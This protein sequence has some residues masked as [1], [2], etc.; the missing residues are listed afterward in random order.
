MAFACAFTMFAG[1]AFTDQADIKATEAVNMLTALGVIDGYDDGSFRPDGTVTRA[2]MAKMIFVVWNGGKSDAK[3]YQTMDSAFADTKDH[4]ARGYINFCASNNIIAGKSATTFAPDATVTGQEAAKMLLTVIGYD[5]TKAGL[6]GPNWKQNTMSY[7]GMCGLFDDVNASVESALPRQYAAQM[8]YNALDTNRVKWSTDSNSFDDVQTWGPSGFTKETVGEKYM[9][10]TTKTGILVEA[11][12]GEGKGFAILPQRDNGTYNWSD[13][14]WSETKYTT[15]LSKYL[16]E[17]VKVAYDVDEYKKNNASVFGVYPTDENVVVT[18]TTNNVKDA[19]EANKIKL[20]DT[21][22]KTETTANTKYFKGTLSSAIDLKAVANGTFDDIATEPQTANTIKFV[23][24]DNNGKFDLAIEFPMA[25]AKVSS[26]T[27]S[28]VTVK[29]VVGDAMSTKSPKLEDVNAYDGIKKDD[30][31]LVSYD[32]FNDEVKIEKANTVD[33]TINGLRGT[34]SSQEFKIDSTWA[35][36][37][38]GVTTSLKSGD[39]ATVVV[40][41]G[42]VYYADRTQS[43]TGSDVAV[44]VST[45]AT[46]GGAENGKVEAKLMFKDGTTSTVEVK[47]VVN[48]TTDTKYDLDDVQVGSN[49]ATTALEKLAVLNAYLAAGT[50][51]TVASAPAASTSYTKTTNGPALVT[52]AKNSDGYTLQLLDANNNDAGYDDVIWGGAANVVSGDMTI[53]GKLFAD[54]AVVFVTYGT[55]DVKKYT[56]KQAKNLTM[57]DMISSNKAFALTEKSNGL[58]RIKVAALS[59]SEEPS[60]SSTDNYAYLLDD[61]SSTTIDGNDYLIMTAYTKNGAETL[62]VDDSASNRTRYAKGTIITFDYNG[63]VGDNTLID[64]VDV[65]TATTVHEAAVTGWNGS[66]IEFV[67]ADGDTNINKDVDTDD[68][69]VLVVDTD[70]KTGVSVG[71]D[72]ILTAT[73]VASK[74]YQVNAKYVYVGGDSYDLIVIDNQGDWMADGK[75]VVDNGASAANINDALQN[76]D[77]DVVTATAL[78]TTGTITVPAGKTLVVNNASV[79]DLSKI[80][81]TEEGAVVKFVK[82]ATISTSGSFYTAA[83]GTTA[84]TSIAANSVYKSVK[85][86]GADTI[87]CSAGLIVIY[88]WQAQSKT[89]LKERGFPFH[90]KL[91][92][93]ENPR[94]FSGV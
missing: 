9:G 76:S 24:Y 60:I 13:A 23:D 5:Q 57:T 52:Y 93:K 79:T 4:W 12:N 3:A 31:V 21:K 16:G 6:V 1:A 58:N 72:G 81:A 92:A 38:A 30:V 34:G 44:V 90:G 29:D 15:D 80:V 66:D 83:N 27:S 88:D 11:N 37:H 85:K 82:A 39:K 64:N 48:N 59:Y 33:A 61:T 54:D 69:T 45:G 47:S 89:P 55:S 73:E 53:G 41:G 26:V 22:Y 40:I 87:I 67:A 10:Y 42:I 43:G 32:N 70:A 17:E 46:T 49:K 8:I 50:T 71:K 91:Q 28:T 77:V 65:A 56:G 25:V 74:V 35:K 19:K 14:V 2:Q 18:T 86:T 84:V 94:V 63:T 36:K 62:Y 68:T 75:T 78:P 51:S 20:D 7:A